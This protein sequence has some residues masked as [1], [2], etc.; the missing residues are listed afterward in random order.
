MWKFRFKK[1]PFAFSFPSFPQVEKY[2]FWWQNIVDFGGEVIYTHAFS[3]PYQP[4]P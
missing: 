2:V 4:H 3:V 1:S